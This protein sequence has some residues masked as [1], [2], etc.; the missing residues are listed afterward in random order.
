MTH[1][2][3]ACDPDARGRRAGG[4]LRSRTDTPTRTPHG[5]WSGRWRLRGA[6]ATAAAAGLGLAPASARASD[7]TGPVALEW[8]AP[9][10]SDECPDAVHIEREVERLLGG[11]ST[12]DGPYLQARAEVH[13]G[14]SG[15][16]HVELRT[17]G[18]QG[19]GLRMVTAE[20]CRAL[21]DATALILALA[22]EPERA[23]ASSSAKSSATQA[24][25][26][27][28]TPNAAAPPKTAPSPPSTSP[29]AVR[30]AADASAMLDIGTLPRAAPGMAARLAVIPGRL[31]SLR[32]EIGAGLFLDE[33]T[34]SPAARSGTFSLRTFDAGGC[35]LKSAPRLEIGACA[36]VEVAWL[37]ASGLYETVTSRGEA[38]WVVLRARATVAYFWSSAWG[39]RADAGGGLGT[40]RPDFTSAGAEQGLIHRPSRYTGQGALGLE[41]RF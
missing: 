36:S 2:S 27:T 13:R 30:F 6:L 18:P 1:R 3:R 37:S 25:A 19:A 5:S 7:A 22:V 28:S 40:S 29:R 21:A 11:V 33:A 9:D 14:E 32:L 41:L 39:V 26:P 35:V 24:P 17:A 12:G 8:V 10:A 20:S 15:L 16:W 23:G 34:T 38:E 31:P 4:P